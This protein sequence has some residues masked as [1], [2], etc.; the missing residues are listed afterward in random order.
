MAHTF[1]FVL[2]VSSVRFEAGRDILLTVQLPS[3]WPVF[4]ASY[5]TKCPGD[6]LLMGHTV[7]PMQKQQGTRLDLQKTESVGVNK[8]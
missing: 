6:Q 4:G 5:K 7:L 2:L 8:T 3:V 1:S